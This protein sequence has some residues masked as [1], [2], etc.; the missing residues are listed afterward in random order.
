MGNLRTAMIYKI[1]GKTK[2][3][4]DISFESMASKYMIDIAKCKADDA[5]DPINPW[6]DAQPWEIDGQKNILKGSKKPGLDTHVVEYDDDGVAIGIH[7]ASV[8]SKGFTNNGMIKRRET[9]D[10]P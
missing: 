4:K 5:P 7:Q 1:M 2:E 10:K 8:V 9:G 3:Y 6:K